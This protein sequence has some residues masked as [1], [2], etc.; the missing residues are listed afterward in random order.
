MSAFECF[1]IRTTYY[2]RILFVHKKNSFVIPKKRKPAPLIDNDYTVD[3]CTDVLEV[4]HLHRYRY[5]VLQ[6]MYKK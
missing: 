3:I 2:K 6:R 5:T 4:P 1:K